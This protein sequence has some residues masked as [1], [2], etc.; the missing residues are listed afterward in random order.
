MG[1]PRPEPEQLQL[2]PRTFGDAPAALYLARVLN[3]RQDRPLAR[4]VARVLAQGRE[5]VASVARAHVEFDALDTKTFA[6][7][8]PLISEHLQRSVT[9]SLAEQDEHVRNLTLN[10]ME[11]SVKTWKRRVEHARRKERQLAKENR[12]H[13]SGLFAAPVK[14]EVTPALLQERSKRYLSRKGKRDDLY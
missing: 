11:G 6:R 5:R 14:G 13:A 12:G 8:L 7:L 9:L 3:D 2:D 10:V 1:S 4:K